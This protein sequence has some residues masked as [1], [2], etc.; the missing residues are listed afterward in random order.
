VVG[1]VSGSSKL[2]QEIHEVKRTKIAATSTDITQDI[3]P[4]MPTEEVKKKAND[5]EYT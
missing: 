4:P 5:A 3:P 1:N 2:T